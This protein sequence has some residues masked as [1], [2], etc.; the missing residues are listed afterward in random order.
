MIFTILDAATETTGS[1]DLISMIIP[2]V[3]L[4]GLM[5]LMIFLPQKK[6]EKK[7]KAML[8]AMEVGQDVVTIG[9]IRGRIVNIKDDEVTIES[10]VDRT[11]ITLNKGAIGEVKKLIES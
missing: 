5:Y 7:T 3:I 6:R 1:S 4:F 10:G 11:K 2:F 8:A 9:G